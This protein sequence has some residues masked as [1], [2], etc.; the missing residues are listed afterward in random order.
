MCSRPRQ[1][2]LKNT[3]LIGFTSTTA[4]QIQRPA[5]LCPGFTRPTSSARPR[6]R[7]TRS[8]PGR[9]HRCPRGPRRGAGG[10]VALDGAVQWSVV[11]PVKRL[12]LAKSRLR[13]AAG[14]GRS[15]RSWRS[16]CALDTVAAALAAGRCGGCSWSPTTR[17]RAE[18]MAAAGASGAAGRAGRRAQPG[19]RARRGGR[20]AAVRARG[21]AL[22]SADLPALRPAELRR[23]AGGRGR[24]RRRAFVADARGTGTTL[25][26]TAPGRPVDAA[27]RPG[28]GRGAPG[29]RRGRADRRLAER[30]ATT[31]TPRP[32]CAPRPSSGS[33]GHLG[34]DRHPRASPDGA[35]CRRRWRRSTRRPA[36]GPR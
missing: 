31:S 13:G 12:R 22:L 19:A 10:R 4:S 16:R 36:A 20:D 28:L 24:A 29:R 11:V 26:A 35:P 30:C 34:L 21:V 27:V 15:T 1:R 7:C 33:A 32:T 17:R 23:R 14:R 5:F 9:R 2:R 18:A 25:L 8:L 6:R 3:A